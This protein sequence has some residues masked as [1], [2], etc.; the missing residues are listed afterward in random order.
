MTKIL[1]NKWEILSVILLC[2]LGIVLRIVAYKNYGEIW[3]DELYSWFFASQDTLYLTIKETVS[4]D[5]HM[6][7]YFA[8]L[9]FWIKLFGDATNTM[10][11]LSVILSSGKLN[12][13]LLMAAL[14]RS[15]ASETVL[16]AMP[17]I[18]KPGRPRLFSPSISMTEP[19]KPSGM[20]EYV[21]AIMLKG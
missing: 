11:L 4:F 3:Y 7:L 18:L 20:M 21:L 14:T 2:I 6:P 13:A 1:K 19:L 5:L 12:P 16:L 9:H 15:R 10:R 17:T 8:I